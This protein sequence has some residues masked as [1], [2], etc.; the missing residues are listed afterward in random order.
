MFQDQQVEQGGM[1]PDSRMYNNNSH[2]MT[3][4]PL[5]AHCG[6]PNLIN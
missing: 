1:D 2:L 5:S 6:G 3:R 4:L